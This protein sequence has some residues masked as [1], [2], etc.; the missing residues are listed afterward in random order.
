MAGFDWT[1]P[2]QV[3]AVDGSRRGRAAAADRRAKEENANARG[4]N[5]NSAMSLMT[6]DGGGGGSTQHVPG[7]GLETIPCRNRSN[8]ILYLSV[9]AA[10]VR[11]RA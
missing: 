11:V 8:Q 2:R 3:V 6:G 5:S 9:E 10:S 4:R 1:T 7:L